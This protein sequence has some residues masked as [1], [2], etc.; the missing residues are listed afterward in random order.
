MV[1]KLT[2][3]P[4]GY[5]DN[6]S[7][8]S[9]SNSKTVYV[10]RGNGEDQTSIVNLKMGQ[11][12]CA[13]VDIIHEDPEVMMKD[14]IKTSECKLAKTGIGVD[15][16]NEP[17]PRILYTSRVPSTISEA[18]SLDKSSPFRQTPL[19]AGFQGSL[20]TRWRQNAPHKLRFRPAKAK[21]QANLLRDSLDI[22]SR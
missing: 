8:L 11:V 1:L 21:Q 10:R 14:D 13:K 4:W 16:V 18:R 9:G 12:D 15:Q 2:R 17:G 7:M 22:Q 5:L 3:I 6:S 20:P 19:A